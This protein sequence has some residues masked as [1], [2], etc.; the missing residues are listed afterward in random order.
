MTELDIGSDT[1]IIRIQ[2]CTRL[3]GEGKINIILDDDGNVKD[4]YFQVLDYRGFEGFLKG[5]QAEE[6]PRIASRVCGVCSWA[7]HMASAKAM[8]QIF[9]FEPT[10]A[11]KKL[12]EL[13]YNAHNLHSHLLHFFVLASPDYFLSED[14]EPSTRNIIGLLQK[15]PDIAKD[16]LRYHADAEKIQEIIA[17]KAVHPVIALPGGVSRLIT[18]EERDTIEEMSKEILDFTLDF[19]DFFKENI[20]EN[21]KYHD[22]FFGDLYRLETYYMGLV[23]ENDQM[24]FYDG[25]LKVVSPNGDDSFAFSPDDYLDHIEE[26]SQPWSYSKFPYLKNIGWKGLVDGEESGMYRVNALPR[27]NVTDG[28]P[29]PL[30]QEAYEVFTEK[31]GKPAHAT[32]GYNWARLIES[33]YN[34]ERMLELLDDPDII[35]GKPRNKDGSFTGEGVGCVEAPRGTLIHHYKADEKARITSANLIVPTTM[36]NAAISLDVKKAAKALVHGREVSE[37][38][39]NRVEMAYRAYDPCLSC[40]THSLPGKC[41]LELVFRDTNG[42][43]IKRLRR[44]TN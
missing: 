16:A 25:D 37:G 3:E 24:N 26:I 28:M 30:A 27:L 2:P 34:I 43:V 38:I 7:H 29:T 6:I 20:I 18:E 21:D 19:H 22:L 23:D 13:S 40:S 14:S 1:E 11:S 12:R 9:G 36:N 10:P 31:L 39:L 17:G 4:A 5:R 8:D 42:N 15:H 44:G 41:P 35:H 33:V 32:L